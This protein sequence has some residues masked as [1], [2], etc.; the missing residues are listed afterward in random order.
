MSEAREL[1]HSYV[2]TEHLLLGLLGDEQ[3]LAVATL[4]R[5]GADNPGGELNYKGIGWRAQARHRW[6]EGRQVATR[7]RPGGQGPDLADAS[8]QKSSGSCRMPV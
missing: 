8:A 5:L 2:G 7:G 6:W 1:N 3:S 4:G